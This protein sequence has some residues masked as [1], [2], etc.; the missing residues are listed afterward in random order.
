MNIL[1]VCVL[2]AI[3][4]KCVAASGGDVGVKF[5]KAAEEGNFEW[6][7]AHLERWQDRKDLLDD[8]IRKSADFTVKFIQNVNMF[9]KRRVLA[10]LFDKGEGM[11]DEVLAR[12]NYNDNDL[13][14]LTNFRPEMAGSPEKFIRLLDKIQ[15]PENQEWAVREG[16]R[17]LFVAGRHDLVAPLVNALGK[18]IFNGESLKE[19]AIQWMFYEGAWRGNQDIMETYCEHPAITPE[20]YVDVLNASW[21][22][23]KPNQVF[24]FLLGQADQEDLNGAKKKYPH[25]Y[26]AKFRLAIDKALETAPPAGSKHSRFAEK[27]KEEHHRHNA[28]NHIS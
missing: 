28:T 12:I 20:V 1:N 27:T 2:F 4:L 21:N 13:W 16:V 22:N 23:G 3:S 7:N 14:D 5:R 18:R 9:A 24:Q 17:S 15:K 6:L 11:I 19:E 26:H 8:V 25:E 10:A